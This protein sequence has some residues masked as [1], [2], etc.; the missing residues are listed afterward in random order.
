MQS[1]RTSLRARR[2]LRK[3]LLPAIV[4]ASG[5]TCDGANVLGP[6]GPSD[7]QLVWLS[8]SLLP[9]GSVVQPTLRVERNGEP[10]ADPRLVLRSADPRIIV[11][12]GAD[13]LSATG[14]G[15]VA[16]SIEMRSSLLPDDGARWTRTLRVVLQ[17]LVLDRASVSLGS[18]GDTATLRARP[19][20]AGGV[21]Y[22]VP[23]SWLSRDTTCVVVDA[24]RILS[25]RQCSTEVIAFA[26]NDT[27]RAQV[28]VEQRLARFALT[29]QALILRAVNDTGR[30]TAEALDAA[31]RPISDIVPFWDSENR[32]IAD[33]DE[34]GFVTARGP[35]V[36]Y[37][38]ASK[39]PV[40]NVVR[41]EVRQLAQRVV[42]P[43]AGPI[44]R[45]IGERVKILATAYDAAGVAIPD[46]VRIVWRSL[47]ESVVAVEPYGWVTGLSVGSAPVVA[48]MNGVA[49][50][51]LVEVRNEPASMTVEPRDAILASIGDAM[52]LRAVARNALGGTIPDVTPIWTS[53]SDTVAAV[54]AG[55]A[56]TGAVVARGR[57]TA[58]ITATIG[59][60]SAPASITVTNAVVT[61][62]ILAAA[63]TIVAIGGTSAPRVDAR[64]ARGDTV[65][66]SYVTWSS[67]SGA[68]ATVSVAG[69]ITARDTGRA[70]VVA[71]SGA[72]Q[73]SLTIVVRNDPASVSLDAATDTLTRPGQLVTYTATV[74]NALGTPI[75]G[76]PASWRTTNPA[77]AT[78]VNGT[79]TSTGY[80]ATLIIVQAGA[81]ADSVDLTVRNL[82]KLHV[83]NGDGGTVGVGT[84]R[85]P[86]L[87]M[88]AAIGDTD[89]GDTVFV[90]VGARAYAEAVVLSSQLTLLGDDS[91]SR[92]NGNDPRLLPVIAH[93]AGAAAIA[94]GGTS[95]VLIRSLAVRHTVDGPALDATGANVRIENLHV[96]PGAT[97]RVGR[98]ILLRGTAS[99]SAVLDSR[100]SAVTSYGIRVESV[101]NA[102]ITRVVVDG[103]D[104]GSGTGAGIHLVGGS[105]A[106]VEYSV[107]RATVGPRIQ[108][109]TTVSARILNDTLAGRHQLVRL[110]GATGST[111]VSANVFTLTLQSGDPFSAGS[112]SDGRS[113]LEI[114]SS[115]GVAVQGNSFSEPGGHL[116]DAIRLIDSRGSAFGGVRTAANAFVGGRYNVRSTRS[117]WD[118]KN[119][120]SDSAIVAVVAEETDS[121]FLASDT[122]ANSAGKGCVDAGGG[123]SVLYVTASAFASCTVAGADTGAAAITVRGTGARLTVLSALFAGADATAI[124]FLG[125]VLTVGSSTMSGAGTRTVSRFRRAAAIAATASSAD[126]LS[127]VVVD[128]IGLTG[129]SLAAA[130]RVEGNR[131]ARNGIGIS[132]VGGGAS[133]T[134]NDIADQVS[135]GLGN[136][137]PGLLSA[138]RN[139][140]GDGR[141]PRRLTSPDAV[142]D[143]TAGVVDVTPLSSGPYFP[144]TT[145][146]VLRIVRGNAQSATRGTVLPQN[147][148]LRVVDPAGL[149][150]SGVSVTFD[151]KSGAGR[152]AGATSVTVTS[153][154]SGLAEARLTLGSTAGVTTVEAYPE[155][156][157]QKGVTFTATAQ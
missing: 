125:E 113:A 148:S 16:V 150:V 56:Q 120:R 121:I 33:V 149:P 143:S 90:H 35:G 98:G 22:D 154:A 46:S 112:S 32:F 152:F 114:R 51:V 38:S 44:L 140:W 57:G 12:N 2:V 1:R 88:G 11:V 10:V 69:L 128:Y 28:R 130:V 104:A 24:G 6:V 78:V 76:S 39:G 147:L 110:T 49:D 111:M 108:L 103:V 34:T 94:V 115:T 132:L 133:V 87:T 71:A 146:D 95:S 37:V 48:E 43:T 29:P 42:L 123:G 68:V 145:W 155:N 55:A 84:T 53:S 77:V 124:D 15:D 106:L 7:L 72:V 134:G 45:S 73:D 96:N 86:Y 116:M 89:P 97:A 153:N 151:V 135:L 61:L 23:V 64:N 141:G 131:I 67:R 117:S 19:L 5:I 75:P 81:S 127:S 82:T 105:G 80:G 17:D 52:S 25:R 156:R 107:V 79:T 26:G 60:L 21:E 91:L 101:A 109:D 59:T 20:G 3:F 129:L 9:I 100:V 63:D 62:D 36:T 54:T 119:S 122:L 126:I 30:V 58:T 14:L 66:S 136:T 41:V 92:A 118:M 99:G 157:R 142:G 31:D 27:A 137:A 4:A 13:S 144:G 102:Q 8:D 47:G 40:R 93:D 83:D 65:P 74:L 70:V 139:W 18:V 138:P 85:R 50:T